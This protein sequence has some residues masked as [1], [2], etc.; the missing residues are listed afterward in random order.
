MISKTLKTFSRPMVEIEK[1]FVN[2]IHN[3]Y[4]QFAIEVEH[5]ED[6]EPTLEKIKN[7]TAGLYIKSD[8]FN[9]L[10]NNKNEDSITVHSIPK[11]IESLSDCCDWIYNTYTPN[12]EYALASI[13]ADDHRIVINSNH[14]ITDGGYFV[15]LLKDI[16]DPSKVDLFKQKSPIPRDLRTDLLKNEFDEF[17]RNKSK[18]M[19]HFPCYQQKD[20]SYLNLQE[21][22]DLPDSYNLLPKRCKAQLKCSELSPYIFNK[23]TNKLNHM[24]EF[25]WTGLCMAINAKNGEYG[26]IGLANCMDLRRL[27]PKERINHYFGNAYT[28]FTMSVQNAN[29]R[30]TISEICSSF[31][32]CFNTMKENEWFYKEYMFPDDFKRENCSVSHV[33]NVG[34]MRFKSPYK[35]FYLQCTQKEEGL[36]PILQVTSYSK[37]KEDSDMNDVVI[38]MRYSP[39]TMSKKSAND[40]FDTYLYFLKNVNPSMK[41]GDVL[42]E[43]IHFQKSLD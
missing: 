34:P 5:K 17:I 43:L 27:L 25:L 13:A 39:M 16:Q 30:M 29:P 33:S 36:R 6:L 10:E 35:D 14:S 4:I 28:D 18:Y 1:L 15:N 21:V 23:K 19:K 26:P 24:S 31:R 42:D 2:Q 7:A 8:G 38:H 22:V 41:S 11:E 12:I 3:C 32:N 9:L 40:I 20:F 37:S